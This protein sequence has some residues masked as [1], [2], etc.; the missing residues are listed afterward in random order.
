MILFN[1][2]PE[3]EVAWRATSFRVLMGGF[4]D[5]F[6]M[7][8]AEMFIRGYEPDEIVF[9]DT[10]SE[11]PHTYQF[12]EY[13]KTWCQVNN[14]SKV[15]HL[16]KLD[17]FGEPLRLIDVVER[18]KTLPAAAFGKKSC[19]L[20]YK[21]ETAD[22]YFNNHPKAWEAWGVDKK[23]ARLDTHTGSIL[24]IVGINADEPGRA[25][26]W[27]P[28]DKWVQVFPLYDWGIGEKESEAVEAVGLYYPGKSSCYMCPHLT[29]GELYMLMNDYPD[30][31][32]RV[33]D[34]EQTYRET[35]MT[36]ESTTRGLCRSNTIAEKLDK[37]W[38]SGGAYDPEQD[39]KCDVC[40]G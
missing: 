15:V 27:S 24:R 4:G 33:W 10:G 11:F 31:F 19:S 12:L 8:I 30:L 29:G 36:A 25:A 38:K 21:T 1:E 3:F 34:L 37:W 35:N 20:R 17:R 13:V 39:K 40:K 32:Q 5:D 26:K 6:A 28:E 14:W 22:K 7:L 9:C 23:G 16:K 2:R 18:E